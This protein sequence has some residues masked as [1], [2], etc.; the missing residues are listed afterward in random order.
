V[1]LIE[2]APVPPNP[3]QQDIQ[4]TRDEPR[5]IGNASLFVVDRNQYCQGAPIRRSGPSDESDTLSLTYQLTIL[6]SVSMAMMSDGPFF[7]HPV[8][9]IVLVVADKTRWPVARR[10]RQQI[11]RAGTKLLGVVFNKRRYYIPSIFY[12]RI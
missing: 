2:S 5:Q 8:D 6:D 3:S 7:R 1:L 11:E 9:G 10:L 4:T 12:R